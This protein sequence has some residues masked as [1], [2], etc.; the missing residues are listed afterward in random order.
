MPFAYRSVRLVILNGTNLILAVGSAEILLGEWAP[1]S[2]ARSK[3]AII[4]PQSAA[5]FA[6]QSV[7]LRMPTQAYV[8]LSSVR[9]PVHISWRLPWVGGFGLECDVPDGWQAELFVI[10]DEPAA[11]AA[12][13]TLQISATDGQ[14]C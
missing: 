10:D 11:V 14:P 6:T 12:L 4:P 3:V 8:Q 5:T 13:L 7:V 9:G 1:D 2:L